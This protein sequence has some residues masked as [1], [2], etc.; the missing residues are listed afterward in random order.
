MIVRKNSNVLGLV[1]TLMSSV[2]LGVWA[3]KNTIAL[4]NILLFVGA[5][6][7]ALY[8]YWQYQ[9]IRLK[10]IKI[11]VKYYLPIL[12]VAL[13][14]AWV[15][16]HYLFLSRFPEIQ[17]SEL[18]STWLRALMASIL[19]LGTGLAILRRPSA[20]NFLWL[21]ILLSF[22]YLFYQYVPKAVA[23]HSLFAP[24]YDGYIF[25]GKI[26]AVLSGT[27]LI[28]GL[29][30]TVLSRFT[31][32]AA[33]AKWALLAFWL[34]GTSVA[35]YASVFI[36]DTRNGVGL[37]LLLFGVVAAGLF[38]R[39]ILTFF[40]KPS[41][42]K[43]LVNV[44]FL[45]CLLGIG[46]WFGWS[47]FKLN[48][49]WATMFEDV[50]IAMQV[51]EYPN[52]QNPTDLGFPNNALGKE[53]RGNTYERVSWAVAGMTILAPENPLG[54]GILVRPFGVLLNEKYP[55]SAKGIMSSHSAWVEFTL[56]FGYPGILLTL[57]ALVMIL[58]LSFSGLSKAHQDDQHPFNYLVATL[59][60]GVIALYTVGEVSSQHGAEM[61][62]FL[63]ALMTGLLIPQNQINFAVSPSTNSQFKP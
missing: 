44:L 18:R 12:L 30:G 41:I 53:V 46:G 22:A 39:L 23:A 63:I 31:F 42:Q 9:E 19:G 27:I 28:C 6:L 25:Y 60:F 38:A 57:G 32:L 34:F 58:V 62:Y 14:F 52:W 16:F 47:Q 36:F 13:M 8:C 55:D 50:Q 49:G 11:L 15:L 33:K 51:D 4:R 10:Q 1:L 48:P 61:L 40:T 37:A 43:I 24:D 20:I 29:L 3:V 17:W 2:L 26:S 56:A 21:G 35:L 59:A 54:V 5:P 7:S 45:V